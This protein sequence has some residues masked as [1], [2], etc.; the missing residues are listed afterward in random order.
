MSKDTMSTC[1]LK[2]NTQQSINP[3]TDGEFDQSRGIRAG[4]KK[5]GKIEQGGIAIIYTSIK[6]RKII[7]PFGKPFMIKHKSLEPSMDGDDLV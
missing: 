6:S 4:M 3:G 1:K 7:K 2:N 5:K